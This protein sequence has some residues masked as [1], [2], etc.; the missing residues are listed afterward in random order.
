MDV[1]KKTTPEDESHGNKWPCTCAFIPT[2]PRFHSCAQSW[3]VKYEA[4]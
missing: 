1:H 4:P 3:M 2:E